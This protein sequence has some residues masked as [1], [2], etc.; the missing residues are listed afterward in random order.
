MTRPISRVLSSTA[1]Y[2]DL[3]LPTGSSRHNFNIRRA[4]VEDMKFQI[5]VASGKVCIA[6][7]S[8]V[9]WYALTAPF[10]HHLHEGGSLFLLHYFGSRL[11]LPLAVTLP[12]DAR[13][14]LIN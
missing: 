13:T 2:L 8:P 5:D 10:H 14:F 11:R 4:D 6:V 12:C 1:I 9:L 3:P 7:Q